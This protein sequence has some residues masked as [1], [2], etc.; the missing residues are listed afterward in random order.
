MLLVVAAV[1]LLVAT[2]A[3]AVEDHLHCF[4]IKDSLQLRG[5]VDLESL[6]AGLDP[7]CRIGKPKYFCTPTGA[8]PGAI[9]ATIGGAPVAALPFV[10]E[11]A[12]GDRVCYATRCRK[13]KIAAPVVTDPF[14]SRTVKLVRTGLLCTPAVRGTLYCGDGLLGPGE[15][16]DGAS[17]GGE[18]CESLGFSGG[19]LGC[20]PGCGSFDTTSCSG[21]TC[22]DGETRDCGVDVGQCTLGTQTCSGGV[23]GSCVGAVL[24]E[25]ETCD[26]LDNDCDGTIDEDADGTPGGLC[27]STCSGGTITFT[28]DAQ[29]DFVG[30]TGFQTVVVNDQEP[31]LADDPLG[32]VVGIDVGA[33]PLPSCAGSPCIS[34]WDVRRVFFAYE[35]EAD[36]LHVGIDCFGTCGDAD[37]DGNP[38][39]G[40]PDFG[41]LFGGID[42]PDL[43]QEESV[44]MALDFDLDV[45]GVLPSI[46]PNPQV[47]W[48]AVLG[49]PGQQP[50]GE[51]PLP[52]TVG[53]TNPDEELSMAH[54]FGLYEHH[55]AS[56]QL[57]SGRFLREL[58]AAPAFVE[59]R[60]P[61]PSPSRPDLEF[62]IGNV[63]AL[64]ALSGASVDPGA[65]WSLFFQ[66]FMG[67][68]IDAG[69]GEDFLPQ[70]N[71]Y[72]EVSFPACPVGPS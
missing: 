51:P 52:C 68:S 43:S 72:V 4:Q 19:V 22:V 8:T 67:S 59:N 13:R 66:L 28:G 7:D 9:E 37:G 53:V 26:S 18:T 30:L 1:A 45:A 46:L 49:V 65:A 44:A 57:L 62:T 24:P 11:A 48:D 42:T 56:S 55:H 17:L 32:Q 20:S 29:A 15:I 33:P 63:R 35:P 50:L 58:A 60:N 31:Y 34:G 10:G 3:A 2:P 25:V 14:G 54:C 61:V 27:D 36:E 12:E 64:R 47:P 5:M 69:V 16:C 21:G 71:D 6:E 23:F 40:S 38:S 41:S 39:A 70:Q